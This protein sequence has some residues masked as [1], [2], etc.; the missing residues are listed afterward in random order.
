MFS[1]QL[2]VLDDHHDT[3][4][5]TCVRQSSIIDDTTTLAL[6]NKTPPNLNDGLI[7]LYHNSV[8]YLHCVQTRLLE[9]FCVV[10]TD[11]TRNSFSN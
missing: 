11:N 10:M 6:L 3:L 9:G 5:P 4:L 8:V 2:L 7:A 1:H